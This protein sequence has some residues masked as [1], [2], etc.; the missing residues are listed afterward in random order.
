MM[1]PFSANLECRPEMC[2]TRL[3]ENTWPKNRHLR[4]I[5]Q[6]CPLSFYIYST[7]SY[8]DNRKTC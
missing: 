1:W 3:A 4:N 5:A 8:I 6:I 2:C 7:M